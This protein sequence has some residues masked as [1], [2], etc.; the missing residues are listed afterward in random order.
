MAFDN[1]AKACRIIPAR[2]GFT[3]GRRGYSRR[4]PDHPRTRGVYCVPLCQ[5]PCKGGS[6]PHARGLPARAPVGPLAARIIPARAGFTI[7]C[8]PEMSSGEDH[9]RT[10]GVY[11]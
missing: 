11:G 5:L 2:A 7:E 3:R 9:P 10:R 1:I 6:S 8:R 4:P